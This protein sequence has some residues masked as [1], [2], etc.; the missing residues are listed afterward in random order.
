MIMVFILI[1]QSSH[2]LL[3]FLTPMG[4][5]VQILDDPQQVHHFSIMVFL[6]LGYLESNILYPD[7]ILKL[8]IVQ[9]QVVLQRCH[10][11]VIF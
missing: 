1:L 10:G 7:Q 11:C 5:L 8:S 2:I 4:L 9:L 6:F 3:F